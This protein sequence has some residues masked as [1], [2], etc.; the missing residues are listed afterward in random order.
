M[1]YSGSL[2]VLVQRRPHRVADDG[3]QRGRH[4]PGFSTSYKLGGDTQ[5]SV[6]EELGKVLK[7][8]EVDGNGEFV[9]KSVEVQHPVDDLLIY[10]AIM[11]AMLYTWAADNSDV[12]EGGIY[13]KT[14]PF[15]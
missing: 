5:G 12:L 10:R 6:A 13:N 2:L 8:W 4:V 7:I 11:V 15:L 3:T 9:Y 1:D 14:V